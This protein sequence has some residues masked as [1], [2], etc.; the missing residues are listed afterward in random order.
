MSGCCLRINLWLSRSTPFRGVGMAIWFRSACDQRDAGTGAP[1]ITTSRRNDIV[2][3]LKPLEG[4]LSA[5]LSVPA[6]I[7]TPKP[8]RLLLALPGVGLVR[9]QFLIGCEASASEQNPVEIHPPDRGD[10]VS[11]SDRQREYWLGAN[12][13]EVNYELGACREQ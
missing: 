1:L 12:C 13:P 6:V 11:H 2:A 4:P 8:V 9:L 5:A 7:W 3:A 10:A